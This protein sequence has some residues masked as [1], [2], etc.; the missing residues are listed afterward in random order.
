M[1]EPTLAD[2]MA[3]LKTIKRDPARKGTFT[4]AT[5][6]IYMDISESTCR[7]MMAQKGAP[8]RREFQSNNDGTTVLLFVKV[9]ID[10]WLQSAPLSLAS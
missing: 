3:E 7:R 2:V 1:S 4:F 5:L 8:K 6:A 9:D 10:R